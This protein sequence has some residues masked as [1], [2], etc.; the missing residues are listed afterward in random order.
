MSVKRRKYDGEF[1]RRTVCLSYRSERMIS[2]TAS[3]LGIH[4]S[5][6]SRRR[7][8]YTSA[9]DKIQLHGE[10]T[11]NLCLRMRIT[12]LEKENDI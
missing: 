11:E 6:L 5:V 10:Q 9:G 3:P 12:E 2:E 7:H 8:N 4:H 1:K